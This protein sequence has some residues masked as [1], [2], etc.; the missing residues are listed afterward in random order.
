M[1]VCNSWQC[2][3]LKVSSILLHY[4]EGALG[5]AGVCEGLEGRGTQ[6]GK[7]SIGGSQGEGSV[8]LSTVLH[9]PGFVPSSVGFEAPEK[10]AIGHLKMSI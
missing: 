8:N 3:H 4:A 9:G 10:L 7:E 2:P 6:M 1:C 5:T